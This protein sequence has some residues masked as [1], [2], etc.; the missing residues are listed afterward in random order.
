MKF[1]HSYKKLTEIFKKSGVPG[2]NEFSGEYSVDML[3]GLPSLKIFGHRKV[4]QARN[5]VKVSGYNVIFKNLAWGK[6]ILQ[7][8][9]C[10]E[11]DSLAVI[12]INYNSSQNSFLTKPIFDQLRVVEEGKIY[13]GRFNYFL[14]GKLHFFGYFSLE[15]IK[16]EG[17]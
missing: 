11:I 10:P 7:E 4:F 16:T 17:L 3:S 2:I 8:G 6:F 9:F 15:K 12:E 14:F 1:P 5:G 13:L